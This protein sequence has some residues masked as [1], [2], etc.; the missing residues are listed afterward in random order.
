MNVLEV[1]CLSK[2]FE[3]TEVIKDVSFSVKEGETLV[4]LGPSGSGK[5]TLLR[6]INNLERV[7]GGNIIINKKEMIKEYK[8]NKPIY[9]NKEILNQINLDTGMVFQD[10]NLFPHL[11]VKENITISLINVFKMSKEEADKKANEVLKK[12]DLK[13][14]ENCY[15]CDLSGGQK[16]R[17]SIAR[18]LAINPK[19]IC[20]DEPTSALDPE[21]VGEVLKTIKALA[22]EKR[23][24]IIVTHE[25]KFAEEVA[26][27]VIF[28]DGGIIVEEGKPEEV[29]KKPKKQR[30]KEFLKRYI[31]LEDNSM[32]ELDIEENK[33]REVISF[34][35]EISDIPRESGNEKKI[36]DYLVKFAK[37]RSLDYY[38][39]NNFNVIIRKPA[40]SGYENEEI[41]GFQ[42]HTDMI[43]E[44][45]ESSMHDFS[46]DP[47]K[48]Y[49]DGDFILANGTTLGADNGIG[50][51]Y[52]LAILDS[53]KIKGP[54]LECIFTTQEETTMIGAKEIDGKQIKCK[55]IISLD[56]GKQGKMV[57]SSANCL[58][59]FGEIELDKINLP[60]D[61]NFVKYELVYSN[62]LGGHSGGNI[63]DI[64][65]GNPIKLGI[66]VI[67]KIDEMYIESLEG[68]SRVNVIPR[69]FRI[70][71]YAKENDYEKMK[72]K[73]NKQIRFFG[74]DGKI[75]LNKF[76]TQIDKANKIENCYENSTKRKFEKIEV[77]S[78]FTTRKVI[79]FVNR[80]VNG[81]V[82]YDENNNVILS[83]NMG[84]VKMLENAVRFE[85]SLRSNDII[86]R[87]LYLENLK[88]IEK[89]N[90]INITWEQELKG[91]EPNY[92]SSLVEKC[93][94]IY[95]EI[96]NVDIEVKISQGVLEGGFF[97]DKIKG[98]EYICIGADTYDVHSPKERVSIKSIGEVWDYIKQIISIK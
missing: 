33:P 64:K 88:E 8:N 44:K 68:G 21:L 17:V 56:N 98:L 36:R 75:E 63:G 83:A 19:I 9:N 65:R 41:L 95:K 4:I 26:D 91:I 84:A 92:N 5:S 51:A 39:D 66:E 11:S 76:Y 62:F 71:F 67:S 37:E 74:E 12:M 78:K 57:I 15:P 93:A 47:I 55:K 16:Q 22:K 31:N 34:F 48:L 10:F 40:S 77:F 81:P 90:N 30:T 49:Q 97:N 69:N 89:T 7:D 32:K 85:Y 23:T 2:K 54:E 82:E 43:C 50:V 96:F 13:E 6:C 25:I 70:S 28:M 27:R 46:K 80:F 53:D 72:E 1:E 94:K 3:N 24:M 29:I 86:L 61:E 60:D 73:I 14:K 79:N 87:N 45:I 42:S 18:V 59:W 52:M 35:K 20:M 38:T 58:E